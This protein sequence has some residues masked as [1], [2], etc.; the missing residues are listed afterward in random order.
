[1]IEQRD[2]LLQNDAEFRYDSYRRSPAPASLRTTP[3]PRSLFSHL[4]TDREHA[5]RDHLHRLRVNWKSSPTPLCL[6][7]ILRRRFC[8]SN[9]VLKRTRMKTTPQQHLGRPKSSMSM[10]EYRYQSRTVFVVFKSDMPSGMC[11]SHEY[12]TQFLIVTRPEGNDESEAH[13]NRTAQREGTS[14]RQCFY[15]TVLDDPTSHLRLNEK[16]N[17]TILIQSLK[18]L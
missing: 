14:S 7:R 3:T 18:A 12:D 5:S 1:M 4:L 6:S 9:G 11:S 15:R 17:T 16:S 13:G 2:V 10:N 8:E